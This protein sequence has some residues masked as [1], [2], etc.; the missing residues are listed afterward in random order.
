MSRDFQYRQDMEKF[1]VSGR[2]WL[3]ELPIGDMIKLG[4]LVP[5]PRPVEELAA[6]LRFFDVPSVQAWREKYSGLQQIVAFRTSP[7][8][9]SRPAAVVAWSTR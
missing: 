7:S 8:F 6:C 1:H 4:W 9:D 3:A 5:V 2:E